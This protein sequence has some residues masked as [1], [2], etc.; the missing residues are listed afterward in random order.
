MVLR[1]RCTPDVRY[2]PNLNDVFKA[3]WASR[4]LEK[5]PRQPTFD[6]GSDVFTRI[7]LHAGHTNKSGRHTG[8]M[9]DNDS[10]KCTIETLPHWLCR[11]SATRRRWQCSAVGSVHSSTVGTSN[12]LCLI[13]RSTA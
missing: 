2:W 6:N 10:H 5:F 7:W 9:V 1:F 13:S 3:K 12:K 4:Q 8:Q 11:Y